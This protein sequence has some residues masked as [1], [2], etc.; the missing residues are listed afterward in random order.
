MKLVPVKRFVNSFEANLNKCKLESEGIDCF[1]TNENNMTLTQGF[2]SWLDIK[3]DLMVRESD[4]ERA[5]E[6]I[7]NGET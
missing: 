6:I 7:N 1:L 2:G 3:I 4:Y 5:N